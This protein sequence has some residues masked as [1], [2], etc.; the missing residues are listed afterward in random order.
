[1][2]LASIVEGR[3][4]TMERLLILVADVEEGAHQLKR[5]LGARHDLVLVHNMSAA[6]RLIENV[7]FD[8]IVG[9]IHFDDSRLIDLLK[10]VRAEPRFTGKPFVAVRILPTALSPGVEAQAR[11]MMTVLGAN[12]YIAADGSEGAVSEEQ[13][14]AEI[15]RVLKT[16]VNQLGGHQ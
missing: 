12:A 3:V 16:T 4:S 5:I 13:M 10:A 11:Q 7:D 15:D 8:A 6:M 9:G 14:A 1:M 2:Q